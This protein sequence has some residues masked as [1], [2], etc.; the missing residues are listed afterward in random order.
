[1]GL[2]N[3]ENDIFCRCQTL[4]DASSS[5]VMGALMEHYN[6]AEFK[7]KMQLTLQA[8]CKSGK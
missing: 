2:P 7:F 4:F 1:M 5:S 8:G 3:L 6:L